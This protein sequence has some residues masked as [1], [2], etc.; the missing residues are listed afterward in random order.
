MKPSTVFLGVLGVL[1]LAS[2]YA[3]VFWKH[4]A[5]GAASW[6]TAYTTPYTLQGQHGTL[7]VLS[8]TDSLE[9]IHHALTE[10]HGDR[11]VWFPGDGAAWAMALD[12][13]TL[14]RYLIQPLPSGAWWITK[15]ESNTQTAPPP[16]S[17]PTKHQLNDLPIPAGAIPSFYSHDEGNEVQVEISEVSASPQG[18]LRDLSDK[19][20]NAGWTPSPTNT[21]GFAMFVKGKRVAF[22]GAKAGKDGRTRILR[23]H[24]PLGVK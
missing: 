6:Q 3:E 16:F 19:L 21:G 4:P 2:V 15:F 11:L 13:S 10:Q 17:L 9:Q 5:S 23:L 1:G 7:S 14:V 20:E 24:K 22:L 8:A 12:H 18:A